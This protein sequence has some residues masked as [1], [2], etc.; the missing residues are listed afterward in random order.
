MEFNISYTLFL[1]I[2]LSNFKYHYFRIKKLTLFNHRNPAIVQKGIFLSENSC[3]HKSVCCNL[4][5]YY[6]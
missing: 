3:I 2:K 1:T 4:C 6:W 5:I